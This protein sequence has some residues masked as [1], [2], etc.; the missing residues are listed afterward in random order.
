M[1]IGYKGFDRDLR[2]INTA[3]EIG[4]TYTKVLPEGKEIPRLCTSDGF[5]YCNTLDEVFRWY[6]PRGTKNR[7][8]KIEILGPHTDG[9]NK[10]ITTSFKILEEISIED[11]RKEFVVKY[12]DME[13]VNNLQQSY[14]QIIW[15]GSLAL[16][17]HGLSLERWT[18]YGNCHDYDIIVPHYFSPNPEC[19][20]LDNSSSGKNSGN[21]FDYTLSTNTG[22]PVDVRINPKQKYE[23]IKVG[24][25]YY[26][27]SPLLDIIAAKVKYAQNNQEKH[28]NDIYEL[29]GL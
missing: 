22:K 17:L 1:K 6:S 29:I 25:T 14:P 3:F 13:Y 11:I 28:L 24:D 15:G 16:F 5:H 4:G 19:K 23:N 12:F 20:L 10:S 9:D 26:K 7:F 27:V 18:E 2:C 8:C 21:D